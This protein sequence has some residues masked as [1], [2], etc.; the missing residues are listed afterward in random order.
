MKIILLL[1]LLIAHVCATARFGDGIY[2]YTADGSA[3]HKHPVTLHVLLFADPVHTFI[4]QLADT[5]TRAQNAAGFA[6]VLEEFRA[7]SQFLRGEALLVV[8]D[9]TVHKECVPLCGVTIRNMRFRPVELFR[10]TA[11]ASLPVVKL[12]RESS[13]GMSVRTLRAPITTV[14]IVQLVADFVNTPEVAYA[15]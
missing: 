2:D 4:M 3:V 9:A 15:P 7:A 14:A 13:K 5:F 1:A 12:V 11:E 6:P 8:V 10:V